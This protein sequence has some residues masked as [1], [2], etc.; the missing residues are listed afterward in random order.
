MFRAYYATA[1]GSGSIMQNSKGVKTNAVFALANMLHG[2]LNESF[3]HVLVAFDKGKKTFRHKTFEAYKAQR[4]P[5]PDDF[6]VQ[7]PN[8]HKLV[9]ALGLYQYESEALEADDII[10][11]IAK[12]YKDQFDDV[13]IISNDQDLYQ[14]LD[15]KIS[16]RL[17]KRGT[18]PETKF[19]VDA[20]AASMAIEPSQIP[21]LKGLM[22]DASDNIPGVPGVGEKT[23]LKLIREYGSIDAI[24]ENLNEFKGKLK[25]RLAEHGKAARQY[26]ELATVITDASLPFSIDDLAYQGYDEDV[27]FDFYRDMEFKS[28]LKRLENGTSKNHEK[29]VQ[30]LLYVRDDKT[31]KDKLNS[32]TVVVLESFGAN[33]H[34]AKKLALICLND[35]GAFAIDYNRAVKSDI[36]K[37]FLEDESI[38]KSTFDVKRLDVLCKQDNIALRGVRFDLLLAAYVLNPSNTKE[39]FRAVVQNFGY[40]DVQFEEAVYGKGASQKIP[41]YESYCE[42]AYAKARAIHTLEPQLLETLDKQKQRDLFEQIEMPLA[43]TLATMEFRGVHIDLDALAA[44]NKTLEKDIK[45]LETK[46]HELAGETFNIASPK[47][48]GVILFEKLGLPTGKKLKTGYSTSVDVLRK[49]KNKHEIIP[50]IMEYRSLT[51][52]QNTYVN[53][54]ADAV[55]DDGKIH[56]IYK[57]AFTQ[58]GRLSSIEPNLQNIPI[59]TKLG[60]KIRKAF[61]PEEGAKMLASDYSQI[62]LRVL[63]HMAQ[64]KALIKAFNEG[65]DIHAITARELFDETQSI[66]AEQRRIA[67]AVNFG[68]LYGQSAWGLADD[69]NIGQKE[70]ERF[71]DR[72]YQKFPDIARFMDKVLHA[73]SNQGYVE[74]LFNRRRYIPE[75]ASRIYAQREAGKRTAMNAPIQ[76][77]AADIIKIA[78]VDLDRKLQE[79]KL[80]S[81]LILQIHDELV[82]NVIP[83]EA[84]TVQKLVKET[85]ESAVDLHVPLTVQVALGDNLD[86]AK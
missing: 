57:Q 27:L 43:Q 2:V 24:L 66:D 83:E 38:A 39:D 3:T 44:F 55:N 37:V 75:V 5:M 30:S 73:A 76:G 72:Y 41:D 74:T 54:L 56:T 50:Y 47:Q 26:R 61:I 40:D 78:M 33:Y 69:L 6:R 35:Q 71:I 20:L 85:M 81:S 1:Y 29:S 32:P 67:K 46:I 77:S 79:A 80:K 14:L 49:L 28:L 53:G 65:A 22:G 82:F 51:K 12:Q 19:T 34:H 4:K 23:A 31:L 64:E 36:F 45:K 17:S 16:I 7:L 9:D 15:E 48:L 58:T 68:I 59:R 86:E 63:A 8:I 25:E 11:T 84:D 21:E 62:E 13:E 18:Q 10:A 60:R 42:H 52:L 70:A